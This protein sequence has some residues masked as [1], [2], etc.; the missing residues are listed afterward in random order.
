MRRLLLVLVPALAVT[1]AVTASAG[2]GTERTSLGGRLSVVLPHGWHVV[3]GRVSE[4]VDPVPRALATFH[5][6]FAR[7][8]CECGMPNL[9][10]LPRDGAFVFTWEYTRISRRDLQYFPEHAARFAIGPGAP[11]VSSCQMSESRNFREAGRG[12]Q[13]QIYLGPDAPASVRHQLAAILDS[14]RLS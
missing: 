13:V 3:R 9:A 7:H 14:W 4:V 6:R 10:N 11:R 1:A 5:V 12:F 8:A 2:A